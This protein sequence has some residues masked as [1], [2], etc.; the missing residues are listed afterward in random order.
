M[1]ILALQGA[2]GPVVPTHFVFFGRDRDRIHDSAFLAN[3]H[4][5]GAQLKYM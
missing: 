1:L 3:P 4:I 2:P 5:A